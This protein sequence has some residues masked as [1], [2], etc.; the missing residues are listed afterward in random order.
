MKS[1]EK[2]TIVLLA[3]FIAITVF[4]NQKMNLQ[5]R[6]S[7]QS[8]E[9]INRSGV[10]F[11]KGSYYDLDLSFTKVKKFS[12]ISTSD[13]YYWRFDIPDDKLQVRWLGEGILDGPTIAIFLTSELDPN[14]GE[15][16]NI[17]GF[18]DDKAFQEWRVPFAKNV[19]FHLYDVADLQVRWDGLGN[20]IYA[21][22]TRAGKMVP[23]AM[24]HQYT[25]ADV[26]VVENAKQRRYNFE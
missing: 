8:G 14:D 21:R 6:T 1:L 16:Y 20:P 11:N 17:W 4:V 22:I 26:N 10:T 2:T 13:R 25:F 23:F 3:V 15:V 24:D 7:R 18:E 12:E 19:N 9:K 5:K